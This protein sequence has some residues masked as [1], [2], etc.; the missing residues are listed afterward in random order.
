M[1][2]GG[3]AGVRL[4]VHCTPSL[5]L[6]A[7]PG[8]EMFEKARFLPG[9]RL[10]TLR[11]A[12]AVTPER[13]ETVATQCAAPV[14]MTKVVGAQVWLSVTPPCVRTKATGMVTGLE[15]A[16]CGVR[17]IRPKYWPLASVG[18][19]I[20]TQKETDLFLPTLSLATPLPGPFGPG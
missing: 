18:A 13:F 4:P 15:P 17:L 6:I 2:W 3:V 19:L 16:A 7:V 12:L 10:V 11:L 9:S 8:A 1:T 5:T 14:F 20:V